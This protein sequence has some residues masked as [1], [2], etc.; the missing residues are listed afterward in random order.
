MLP[1][2]FIRGAALL[3]LGLAGGVAS[4]PASS[5]FALVANNGGDG[6]ANYVEEIEA[7]NARDVLGES[8][9]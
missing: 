4:L 2:S 5:D 1:L 8:R 6:H 9:S 7:A 3:V